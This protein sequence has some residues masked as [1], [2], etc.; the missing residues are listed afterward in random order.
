MRDVRSLLLRYGITTAV[1]GAIA[2]GIL[3]MLNVS[4]A[5][6]PADTYGILADALRYPA[7]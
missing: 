3:W 5:E 6:T 7:C 2:A 4:G 1:G